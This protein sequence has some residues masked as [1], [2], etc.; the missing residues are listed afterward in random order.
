MRS[1]WIFS[2]F[3]DQ[4]WTIRF[5]IGQQAGALVQAVRAR[6]AEREEPG[7]SGQLLWDGDR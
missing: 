7:N 5:Q 2:E 6:G 1:R 3:C 4:S